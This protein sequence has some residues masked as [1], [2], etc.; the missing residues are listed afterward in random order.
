MPTPIRG[1]DLSKTPDTSQ[2][3]YVNQLPLGLTHV[4]YDSNNNYITA[5]CSQTSSSNITYTA[6]G[7]PIEYKATQLWIIGQDSNNSLHIINGTSFTGELII[8]HTSTTGDDAIFLCYPLRY[9]KTSSNSQI[10]NIL[11]NYSNTELAGVMSLDI[12]KDIS[13]ASSNATATTFYIQYF[14]TKISSANVLIYT[15]PLVISSIKIGGL[16]NTNP[17]MDIFP[18]P[19]S[20]YTIIP[21]TVPGDWMECDYVP[22]DSEEVA[23][24]NLPLKSNIVKDLGAMGSMQTIILIIS[25]FFIFYF[26]YLVL[27]EVYLTLAKRV[28][29]NRVSDTNTINKEVYRMDLIISGV[30]IVLA[31]LLIL[32]GIG[33]NVNNSGDYLLAGFC[34]AIIYTM[35][36]IIIQAKKAGDKQF[37]FSITHASPP[38]K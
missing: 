10:D 22:I 8:K 4:F 35:G 20:S 18:T 36:Y 21:L 2:S 33:S 12:S 9:S 3:V 27:P 14:S 25:F 26:A 16:R 30:L 7:K 19:A 6:N 24:L 15:N 38:S 11:N 5:S 37:I 13:A 1:F 17:P 29:G 23:T 32:T 34:I 28:I 31:F